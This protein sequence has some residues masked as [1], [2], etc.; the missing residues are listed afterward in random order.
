VF[1]SAHL[2]WQ[3]YC[4]LKNTLSANFESKT[5]VIFDTFSAALIPLRPLDCTLSFHKITVAC[6]DIYNMIT[7][8]H[9]FG[10]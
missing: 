6:D 10:T 1:F 3:L 7:L 2:L 4:N 5:I 9:I 8:G